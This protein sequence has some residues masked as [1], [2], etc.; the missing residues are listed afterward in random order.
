MP[1]TPESQRRLIEAENGNPSVLNKFV[2]N[3]LRDIPATDDEVKTALAY[4]KSELT[5]TSLIGIYECRRAL[6]ESLLQAYETALRAHIE[7]YDK[8]IQKES[9][10]YT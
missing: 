6:G 10:C 8:S 3:P 4:G 9:P 2:F 7:A 1:L 5:S